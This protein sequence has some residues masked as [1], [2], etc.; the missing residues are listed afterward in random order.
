MVKEEDLN[1]TEK[2]LT[3]DILDI[4]GG[5]IKKFSKKLEDNIKK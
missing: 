5:F 2:D 4:G 3:P 1:L